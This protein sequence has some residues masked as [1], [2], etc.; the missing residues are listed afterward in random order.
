MKFF[1][2]VYQV[3]KQVPKGKVVTYGQVARALGSRDARKVGWALHTNQEGSGVPC[4]RVV[5]SQGRLAPNFAFD[6][7]QEQRR[8]LVAEGVSFI[9]NNLVDLDKCQLPKL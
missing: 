8:R 5:N 3:V 9:D 6:G 1:E 2:Q 7:P 4:H